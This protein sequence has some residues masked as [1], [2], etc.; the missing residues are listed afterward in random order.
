MN[1]TPNLASATI[2]NLA[3]MAGSWYGCLDN[4]PIDEHWSVPA[5]GVMTGMF[6]WL[7]NG[8]VYL[9]ELL[10][11]EPDVNGPVLRLKHFDFGLIGWE[12]KDTA[13]AFPLVS[14][15]EKEATFERGGGFRLTRFVYKRIGESDLVAITEVRKG[16]EVTRNE[17][18]YR[19]STS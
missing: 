18:R 12:E 10:V 6:R 1:H 13:L 16:D 14:S 19:R 5:G 7:K 2:E 15:G 17:F 9:Y 11:I 8:K 4:D 3:W